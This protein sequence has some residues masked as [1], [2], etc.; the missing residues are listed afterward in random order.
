MPEADKERVNRE[1]IELLN[2]LRVALPGVQ[3]LFAF[4]LVL[5]FQQGFA[6]ISEA[7]RIVYFLALAVSAIASAMLIAPSVYHRI[8]FRRQNKE[9]MLRDANVLLIAGTALTAVGFAC[10]IFLIADILFGPTIA[11]VATAVTLAIYA[12]LWAA[13]PLYR[14]RDMPP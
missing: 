8:N 10:A 4:L 5:P 13:L 2:E 11:T 12:A 7:D 3:V 6:S 9:R 1:L 14:R